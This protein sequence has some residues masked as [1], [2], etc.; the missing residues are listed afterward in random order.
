MNLRSTEYVSA[1]FEQGLMVTLDRVMSNDTTVVFE[2]RDE[3]VMRGQPYKNRV[4]IAFDVRADK[5]CAYREYF[6]SD[7]K[8]Y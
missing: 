3:G 7:G 4:A 2:F 5:I 8:S 6:G 1:T